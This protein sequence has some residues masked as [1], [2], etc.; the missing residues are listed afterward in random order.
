MYR[1]TIIKS[2][3]AAHFLRN[4][5]GSCEN[6]HGHNWKV[7]VFCRGAE[8]DGAG[9]LI[10]YRELKQATMAIV[11]RLDHKL[12]NDIPPFND[13]WNPS[14]EYIARYFLEELQKTM[15]GKAALLEK[16]RIWETDSSYAEYRAD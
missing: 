9:L 14:S 2:F 12:I 15:T 10:D 5:R 3:A 1:V 11:D 7:E 8:L 13:V 16:V 6:L 4:Y